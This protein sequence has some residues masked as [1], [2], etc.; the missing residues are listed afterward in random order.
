MLAD[1]PFSDHPRSVCPVVAAFFREYNDG[2]TDADRDELLPYA[3]QIVGTRSS[4]RVRRERGRI[5]M[6]WAASA[7]RRWRPVPGFGLRRWSWTADGAASV[8]ASTALRLPPEARRRE[9]TDLV[10]ALLAV[11]DG[12]TTP[13]VAVP[14]LRELIPS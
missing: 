3:A 4:R 8:A 12:T 14:E 5:M 6:E 2:L 9:V 7:N 1:E 13:P 11:G 10:A